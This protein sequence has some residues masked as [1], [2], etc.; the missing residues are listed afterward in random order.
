LAARRFRVSRL[1]LTLS[2]IFINIFGFQNENTFQKI[3][4][5]YIE[6]MSGE[7]TIT[8]V[9][10]PAK[11]LFLFKHRIILG[12]LMATVLTVALWCI[13]FFDVKLNAGLSSG[14]SAAVL[15]IFCLFLIPELRLMEEKSDT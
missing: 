15:I 11:S 8:E 2:P 6:Q 9:R 12:I 13:L 5:Q 1:F 3:N 7:T 10:T 4:N 14:I